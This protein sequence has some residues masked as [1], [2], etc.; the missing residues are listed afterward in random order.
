VI[1]LL[2]VHYV[3]DTSNQRSDLNCATQKNAGNAG[4]R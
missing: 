1:C 3:E 2:P 4:V